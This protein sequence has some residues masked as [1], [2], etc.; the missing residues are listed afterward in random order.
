MGIEKDISRAI[1]KYQNPKNRVK[2]IAHAL[3]RNYNFWNSRKVSWKRAWWD[4]K[5]AFQQRIS[6][7]YA[8]YSIPEYDP[9]ESKEEMIRKYINYNMDFELDWIEG[10]RIREVDEILIGLFEHPKYPVSLFGVSGL[11]KWGSPGA[12]QRLSRLTEKRLHFWSTLLEIEKLPTEPDAGET[13]SEAVIPFL[14]EQLKSKRFFW[15]RLFELSGE[16]EVAPLEEYLEH[17]FQTNSAVRFLRYRQSALAAHP[18]NVCQNC[19]CKAT[20]ENY[21]KGWEH[22]VCPS[23]GKVDFLIQPVK[24]IRGYIGNLPQDHDFEAYSLWNAKAKEA[25]P[26]ELDHLHIV[27]GEDI[28]YNWAIAAVFAKIQDFFP[29]RLGKITVHLETEMRSQLN[30]NSIRILSQVS[31]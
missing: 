29:D 23:C 8:G 5:V 25:R 28:D 4:L 14:E 11:M 15:T 30:E 24:E 16:P 22:I 1:E 21:R 27:K 7:D 20:L 26:G 13:N 12:I 6:S 10:L 3:E 19:V 2:A 31:K 18:K 17:R 9:S